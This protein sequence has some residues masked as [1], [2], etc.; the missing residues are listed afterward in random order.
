MLSASWIEQSV[1]ARVPIADVDPCADGHGY[2]WY[3]KRLRVAD[4]D[5]PATFASGNGGNKIYV[6]TAFGRVVAVMSA[7]YG[8]GYGQRRSQ[9]I[10]QSLL[11]ASAE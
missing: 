7:A 3:A 11:A 8:R 10:L 1:Q 6:V 5:V 2:F 9:G 4:T